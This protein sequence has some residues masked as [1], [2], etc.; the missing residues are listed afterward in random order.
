MVALI[1]NTD[2]YKEVVVEAFF[3][4]DWYRL[5]KE[6]E[7]ALDD[8]RENNDERIGCNNRV[9]TFDTFAEAFAHIVESNVKEALS[10]ERKVA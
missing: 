2:E 8:M 3:G 5:S 9:E 6:A 7:E 4:E 10:P 1:L